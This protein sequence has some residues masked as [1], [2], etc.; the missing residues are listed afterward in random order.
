MD[1]PIN[2]RSLVMGG[3][4]LGG[5]LVLAGPLQALLARPS[6]AQGAGY[7][8]IAPVKDRSTGVEML[9][10]PNGFEYWS[11]GGEGTAMSRDG[12]TP[13]FHDGMAAFQYGSKIH[14]VRNHEVRKPG[15]AFGAEGKAYD[16]RAPGGTT[17]IIFDPQR[18]EKIESFPSLTGT[19]TNCAG[20]RSPR[21]TWFSCEETDEGKEKGYDRPHG[22][23]FEVPSDGSI[24]EAKPLPALGRFSHEALA[25]DPATWIVYLTEDHGKTSGLYRFVPASPGNF[26][27]GRLQ[28]LGIDGKPKAD[29]F[30]GQKMG[31]SLPVAWVD[32]VTP[33]PDP[34]TDATRVFAQGR[35]NDGAAFGRLEGA[36][37]SRQ[38][39][40]VY[41]TAT[42]GGNAEAGQV[43]A[44]TPG[45]AEGTAKTRDT[46]TLLYES[47][48]RDVLFYPD[49]ITVSPGGGLLVCEDPYYEQK[50]HLRGVTQDGKVYDFA[51]NIR[52]GLIPGTTEKQ[53][54]AEFAGATFSRD[55]KWLFVNIQEPGITIAITGP[56][57]KG[58][59]G[60]QGG[61]PDPG[62]D[63]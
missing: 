35:A 45:R 53:S 26:D 33:A 49:N 39:A 56:F 31:V 16:P 24:A 36:W 55:G 37:W 44:L 63:W 10:L 18:P 29:L 28:M 5:G 8:P 58:P 25:V 32:I 57:E 46:L 3:A 9:S 47:P 50:V 14:L 4:S 34:V 30:S 2:R 27:A 60:R 62:Y 21:G 38:D 22:F 12:N 23:V 17:T 7:G 40:T 41:F 59:L 54:Q 1:R 42:N 20:G 11:L 52:P 6:H 43:W 13:N 61:Q 51:E 48:G 19:S 15:K